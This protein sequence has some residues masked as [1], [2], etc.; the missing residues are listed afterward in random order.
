MAKT[1]EKLNTPKQVLAHSKGLHLAPRKM[2]LVTNLVKRMQVGDAIVQLQH[3]NK[4]GSEM[5]I[6]LLRSAIANAEHNFSLNPDDL[7]ISSITC[8]MG[9]VMK[10]YFPRA[11]G[12]AFVIRRKL[13]H[14]HVTLEVKPSKKKNAK[15]SSIKGRPVKEKTVK[16]VEQEDGNISDKPQHKQEPGKSSEKIK[17]ST[18]AQKRRPEINR[19]TV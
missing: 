5:V 18:I 13:C 2:R 16:P 12:S 8:D 11:R 19:K 9:P 1:I 4:K 3:T 17:S 7:V 14:V 15:L 6:K 10:R